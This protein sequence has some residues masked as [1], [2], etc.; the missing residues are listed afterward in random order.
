MNIAVT[1]K[2]YRTGVEKANSHKNLTLPREQTFSEN[3]FYTY[4]A[5]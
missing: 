1:M 3:Y 5:L 4:L 2:L